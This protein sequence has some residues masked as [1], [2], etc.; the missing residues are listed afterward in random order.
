MISAGGV[1]VSEAGNAWH[2]LARIGELNRIGADPD[3]S[4]AVTPQDLA[5]IDIQH[6]RYTRFGQFDLGLG[7][8]RRED[9]ATGI[10]VRDTRGYVQWRYAWGQK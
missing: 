2:V 10:N 5:S 9:I 7:F 8:E 4:V 1:I 3:H 6:R